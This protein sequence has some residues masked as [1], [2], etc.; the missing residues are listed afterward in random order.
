MTQ[1]YFKYFIIFVLVFIANQIY[2]QGNIS[3]IISDSLTDKPLIGANT[4]LLGTA[5]G[6]ATDFD[7]QYRISNVPEGKYTFRISYIGY[8]PK[9]FTINIVSGRTINFDVNLSPDIVEGE[10]VI[11]SAQAAGQV[12]AINQQLSANT[13]VNIVSEEKIQE[14]PD[15][16]AAEAIGRLPGVSLNRSGGEANKII[17]RGLSDKYTSVTIDG[18]KIP[19]T[20]SQER[21]VD[22]STFSQNSLAGIELYKA[23]TSDKEADAIAGSVNLVTKT[24]SKSRELRLVTKGSYNDLMNSVEQYDIS[25][26]YGERFFDQ[27]LGVQFSGNIERKIRS[28]EQINLNYDQSLDNQTDYFINNFT[29]Q[30]SDEIRKRNGLNII[31]DYSTPDE[32]VIKFNTSFNS[33][34][35]DYLTSQRDYPNGGGQTQYLGGVTYSFRDREQQIE[36]FSSALTGEN[37][38]FDFK[39]NWGLSFAQSVTDFPYDY[40]MDFSESS[41]SGISGMKTPPQIKDHPEDLIEY[42]YN[43]FTAA[44]L[45]GAYYRTQNNFDKDK[46]AY[47]DFSRQ[48]NL[49]GIFSGEF[50]FGGK[51][52]T[53]DRT[54]NNTE[55][56]SPYYLGYWQGYERLADG[57][58]ALKDF[59]DS[60]FEAFF[61][62]YLDNSLNNTASFI[63]FLDQN[64]KNRKVFDLYDLNPLINRDKLRQ[65]YKINKN[66]VSQSGGT[67]EY[68]NDP[69]VAANYY[70]ITETVTSAYLMNT[71]KFEQ[72]LT[73][74]AGVRIEEESNH[75]KN[76][77]SDK[78]YAS[79]PVSDITTKDTTSNYTESIILPN[80]HFNI[81]AT[82]FLN[83]RLAAYKALA[84]PDFNMRLNTKFAWRPGGVGSSMQMVVGNPILKTAKAW[85]F[86]VNT[87]F[88]GNEI[89]LISIS[90][91]YK[92][93]E[94]M[95]HMLNG[96]NTTG[97][98]L[99]TA[100][101]LD[102]KT[103]WD[104]SYQL[105]IP[106]NSPKTSKVW[107]FEFEHQ[108]NFTFLP[109][110][111]KN[112]ILSYNASLVKSETWLIGSTTD[113][114]YVTIPPFPTPFPRF[115]ER[116]I[117]YK[118]QLENQPEL[119]GNI[120]IGYDIGG[121]SGRISLFH[122]SEYTISYSPTGRSD[123]KVGTYT[124]LDLALKQKVTDYLSLQL[125][126][127]NLTNLK[128][129]DLL[130][131]RVNNYKI[132]RSSE[133][134]GITADLG[135]RLDL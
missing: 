27:L 39:I 73:F 113:T 121:F 94:D 112:I 85:N 31:L 32:G 1:N 111:L 74:I 48:Y 4:V 117:E 24:A 38:L 62:R 41:Q 127:N 124:R 45:A 108:I 98:T 65:W 51:Y 60:Y 93:I 49:V 90:A 37:F 42:A 101:G 78:R 107:G 131:N 57:S 28:N 3:G 69:S 71:W 128:E 25:L 46:S 13:I 16:N 43:N 70:D 130:D 82:D 116:A 47:L 19:S 54:N 92:E 2:S 33:T 12:A 134:Y 114:T 96:I 123:R 20:D 118:Q 102:T 91:F 21:G 125:N 10:T 135:V 55:L 7:G 50:K 89:G 22:L 99:L 17:L 6:S 106:Y 23:L 58:I 84:R 75:Y 29:L 88:Y 26:K 35:R 52:K 110:L 56:F 109:G 104:G 132:L 9:E 11:V 68:F 119:F 100:L 61:Q 120:S 8:R 72:F 36:T 133:L 5:M 81:K 63:E 53:K 129:D 105:T 15:A 59:S 83:I 76:K 126:V 80:F 87:S 103:L 79:F 86:E 34:K 18:V 77:F 95:Y 67:K 14:L 44:T 66:G 97:D 64:P 115:S 30:F 40:T 122:Q